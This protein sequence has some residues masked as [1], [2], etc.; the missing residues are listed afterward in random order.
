MLPSELAIIDRGEDAVLQTAA[1]CALVT[2]GISARHMSTPWQV[3]DI[4]LLMAQTILRESPAFGV[5]FII[6]VNPKGIN[7]FGID[8]ASG[9]GRVTAISD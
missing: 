7:N 5:S 3:D 9:Y 8:G 2:F 6:V 4:I 1:R